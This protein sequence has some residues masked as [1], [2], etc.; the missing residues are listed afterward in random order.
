MTLKRDL[1]PSPQWSPQHAK[2]SSK[3]LLRLEWARNIQDLLKMQIALGSLRCGP[4]L[5]ISNQVIDGW[6]GDRTLRSK[7]RTVQTH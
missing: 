4:R 5:A 7:N 3:A 6:S 1:Q 2:S